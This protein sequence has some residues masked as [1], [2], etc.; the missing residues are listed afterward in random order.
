MYDSHEYFTG[1][2]EI[3]HR[4]FVL[5]V[6]KQI[7]KKIFPGLEYVYTVSP[8]IAKKYHSEY[9]V[10]V[11]VVRN[12]PFRWKLD[13]VIQAP[14]KLHGNQDIIILQGTGINIDRGAEETVEAMKYVQNAVLWII[15]CGDVI[16][17][18]KKKVADLN[19]IE[20][21]RFFD[22]MPYN[23]LKG[24]TSKGKLGLSLDKGTNP[25]YQMSLPN[26]LF[27]YI[28]AGIPILASDLNEVS[29]VIRQYGLGELIESHDPNHIAEKIC[30]MLTSSEKRK[31]WSENLRHAAEELCWEKEE[32]EL[33]KIYERVGLE[34]G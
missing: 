23:E 12:F 4:R 9:G 28:Q 5:W 10:E 17:S 21:V 20:K 19:L 29:Q 15:G 34:F 26:K 13:Q 1:V 3:L 22:R 14:T 2:P 31:E 32:K 24:Y 27:D 7:E 25:N 33:M 11:N 18:L 30:F 6:W 8:S 16:D